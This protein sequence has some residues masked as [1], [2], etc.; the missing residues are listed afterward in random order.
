[1]RFL[2]YKNPVVA[3]KKKKGSNLTLKS[4]PYYSLHRRELLGQGNH[5]KFIAEVAKSSIR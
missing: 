3:Q 4:I 2:G 1:M 5:E